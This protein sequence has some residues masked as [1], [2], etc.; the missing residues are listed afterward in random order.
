VASQQTV[1]VATEIVSNVWQGRDQ[2][3]QKELSLLEALQNKLMNCL[4]GDSP[5]FRA[6]DRLIKISERR[7][8]LLGLE[9]RNLRV[10]EAVEILLHEEILSSAQAG[11]VFEGI[12]NIEQNLRIIEAQK[13]SPAEIQTIKHLNAEEL[14]REYKNIIDESC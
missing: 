2:L 1:K 6:I 3:R 10:F 13:Q 8:K 14:A 7:C 11:I 5:D 9:I 4:Q 12:E